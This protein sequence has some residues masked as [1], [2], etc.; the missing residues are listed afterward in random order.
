MNYKR[1]F[2]SVISASL[3]LVL[4]GEAFAKGFSYTYVDASYRG[5]RADSIDADG[6]D[7][8]LSYGATDHVM[9]L[10]GYSR[11]FQD[12]AAGLKKVDVDIDEFRMGGG[13]HYSFGDR[14]DLVGSVVY[15]NSKSSGDALFPGDT[16]TSRVNGTNEGYEAV[17]SGRIQALDKLELTPMVL[18]KDVG[19]FSGVGG[20]FDAIYNFHKKWSVRGNYTYFSEDSTSD[21]FL[22]VRLDL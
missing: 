10:L 7:F 8:D 5:I 18:Y 6:V 14:F 15:V 16:S 11:L 20:G 22:G 19:D 2:A 12:T 9:V 17:V 21:F 4:Q 1:L 3:V 13:G